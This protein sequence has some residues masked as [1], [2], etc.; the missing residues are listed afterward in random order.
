[1]EGKEGNRVNTRTTAIAAAILF[2]STAQA[3]YA[4]PHTGGQYPTTF[5]IRNGEID[6]DTVCAEYPRGSN[7]Y[8]ECRWQAK[9][10]FQEQ[11]RSGPISTRETYCYAGRTLSTSR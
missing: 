8:R 3:Q 9:A 4:S 11:C 6:Q 10:W 5:T 7:P 1:M 2:A